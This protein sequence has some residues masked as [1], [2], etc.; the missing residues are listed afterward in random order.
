VKEY[1]SPDYPSAHALIPHGL[2]VCLT[3]PA[4]FAFTAHACAQRHAHAAQL[5][6]AE[7]VADNAD[8]TD[9]GRILGDKIR[10]IMQHFKV[11]NGLQ[12]V[13]Y[14]AGDTHSLTKEAQNSFSALSL[15]PRA[16]TYE[17]LHHIYEQSHTVY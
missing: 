11:P 15:C 16:A 8:A 5:L 14:A 4:V 7:G 17:A 10:E 12:A 1:V 2:S 13:G 9:A 3:A 6:G